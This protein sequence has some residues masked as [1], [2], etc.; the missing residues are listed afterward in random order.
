MADGIV[1]TQALIVLYLTIKFVP[2]LVQVS[3]TE[4][5][6]LLVTNFYALEV[7]R[8]VDDSSVHGENSKVLLL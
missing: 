6:D 2:V 5:S 4:S 3:S 7:G 1:T 8:G